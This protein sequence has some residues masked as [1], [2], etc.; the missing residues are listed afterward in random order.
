MAAAVGQLS[1]EE[2]LHRALLTYQV[3]HHLKCIHDQ[4]MLEFCTR[5]SGAMYKTLS[6]G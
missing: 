1:R 5:H 6:A 4:A 3:F 2:E